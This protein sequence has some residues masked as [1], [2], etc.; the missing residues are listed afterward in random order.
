LSIEYGNFLLLRIGGK[1]KESLLVSYGGTRFFDGD[2]LGSWRLSK[3]NE[4]AEVKEPRSPGGEV[5]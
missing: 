2:F 4:G 3:K 5:P 1:D